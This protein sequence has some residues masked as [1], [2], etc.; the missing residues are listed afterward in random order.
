MKLGGPFETRREGGRLRLRYRG[1][2][3]F[4]AA[5]DFDLDGCLL[6][7]LADR[8][9]RFVQDDAWAALTRINATIFSAAVHYFEALGAHFVPLPLVTRMISS[10]GATFG[11][12]KINYTT[13]MAPITLQ[14]FD[15]ER[16]AFL[17][18][19]S[20][21]YLELL[22]TQPEIDSVYSIYNSFRKEPSDATHL[23]E[24]HHIEYEGKVD[25]ERNLAIARGLLEAIIQA[26]VTH[27]SADLATFLSEDA[28][29]ELADFVSKPAY[30]V[31]TF[32]EALRALYEDTGF[33]HYQRFTLDG[34][35]GLAE[36]VRL[37]EIFASPVILTQF[38][39]LEVAFYHAPVAGV[40]PAVAE[41]G[42]V[43]WP[44]YCEVLGSGRR[45]GSSEEL[46]HKA[47]I[48]S[49]PPNDYRPY[50]QSRDSA[51]YSPTSGF[52]LGWERLVQGLLRL[53]FIWDAVP[54]PR[55]SGSLMP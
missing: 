49:L 16:P 42:D 27:R 40:S 36:E 9:T 29:G 55:V 13:D 17:A 51:T 50:L 28:I 47:D 3:R 30:A 7:E 15:Q 54:F 31:V 53:P 6:A 18:E 11:P 34:N 48:F 1:N 52:G 37:G 23:A 46:R 5:N 43:I 22:L 19:S 14:W 32:R 10:P 2:T 12:N 35:F 26:L 33:E 20:Q 41:C 8:V 44:G 45:V 4:P 38:P 25:Q 24:F 21:I 39:L